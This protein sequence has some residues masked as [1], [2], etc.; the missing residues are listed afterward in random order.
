MGR[1]HIRGKRKLH[2]LPAVAGLSPTR[3]EITAGTD[4]SPEVA[5]MDDFNV[6]ANLIDAPDLGN[7]FTSKVT[8]EDEIGTP[9]LNIY[10]NDTDTTLRTLL[11]KGE[12][13]FL[14]LF[15]HGD[16]PGDI[17][18]VYPVESSGFNDQHDLDA[19]AQA[20]VV[21]AVTSPPNLNGVVP[22]AT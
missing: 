4:L 1:Y 11:A 3:A 15:L 6:T 20:E 21:F 18:Q 10:D 12:E 16:I 9:T 14:C 7:S 19:V 17:V 8:G 13:G 2:F 22:A 5:S